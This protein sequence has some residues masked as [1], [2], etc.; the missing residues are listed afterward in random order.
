MDL[1]G[2]SNIQQIALKDEVY[3]DDNGLLG[4]QYPLGTY[5]FP[6]L[7]LAQALVISGERN[8]VSL[9]LR[10]SHLIPDT[11]ERFNFKGYVHL[12][13]TDLI[14]LNGQDVDGSSFMDLVLT[15]AQGGTGYIYARECVVT[16]ATSLRGVFNHTKLVTAIGLATGGATDYIDFVECYSLM[17]NVAV[18]VNTPDL[19]NFYGWRGS[20][21]LQ[22]MGGGIVNIWAA[23]GAIITIAASCVG[24]TINI[25]GNAQVVNNTGGTVVNNY[26]LGGAVSTEGSYNLPNDVAENTAFTVPAG[27]PD[28]REVS[29]Q[30]DLTNLVQNADIR[31][32]YDM[33]GDGA[34][35]PIMETFNW[36]VGMDPIV[37]FRALSGQR[38]FQVTVQS[39][40]AQGGIVAIDY[41]YVVG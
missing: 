22:T 3:V 41:E 30:L 19:V 37:Y 33:H 32:R 7:T 8:I 16:N 38:A 26:S 40:I 23:D 34:P 28:S 21:T 31:I 1:K 9:R 35:F 39:I 2:Y 5:Q 6:V 17:G 4:T 20:M 36:T 24:G 15:G 10:G 12:D 11:M 29:L 14:D 18:T 25:Y 27:S 13:I